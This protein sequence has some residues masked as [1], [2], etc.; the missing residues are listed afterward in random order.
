[1]TE[2]FLSDDA[3]MAD[4]DSIEGD[5]SRLHLWWLGQSGFLIEFNGALL[6][7]DPYLSDSLTWKYANTDKP[8]VRITR[9]VVDPARLPVDYILST[10]AHTDHLDPDTLKP[11]IAARPDVA[12]IYPRA[13]ESVVSERLGPRTPRRR[14]PINAG[15]TVLDFVT[16]VPA[17]HDKLETDE[18]G[19]HKYLGYVIRLGGGRFTVYHSGD[20]LIYDG[21]VERLRP[22]QVDVAIVPINGKVGNMN[23]V[24][25]AGLAN[26]IGAKV[27]I[28]CHYDM[29]EF[30]TASPAAFEAECRRLGQEF[31]VLRNGQQTTLSATL[32][33]K[34]N[35]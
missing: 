32:W 8:H 33:S 19:N 12:L 24:E 5:P 3:F 30:N 21:L 25:A 27:A 18:H 17:A 35:D 28:P 16:A 22:H 26:A 31:R 9:R 20:T 10:H 34:P 23:G 6:L 4:V 14:H 29:F 15:E 2:P 1:V 11:L 7:I 13:I